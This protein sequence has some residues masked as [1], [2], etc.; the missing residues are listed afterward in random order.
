LGFLVNQDDTF[1]LG[2]VF[3]RNYYSIFD[4]ENNRLGL[5]PH[6]TS[7]VTSE[8]RFGDPPNR[9][10]I[11]FGN[12]FYWSVATW[13]NFVLFPLIIIFIIAA[14]MMC[15]FEK[16]SFFL[17]Y[18]WWRGFEGVYYVCCWRWF[19]TN[20]KAQKLEQEKNKVLLCSASGIN[21]EDKVTKIIIIQ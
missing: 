4:M 3:L 1:I 12:F 5:V 19:R 9:R 13:C 17:F 6:Y 8:N 20:R 2:D 21:Q 14:C 11:S 18:C 15:G 7:D 10:L 16:C